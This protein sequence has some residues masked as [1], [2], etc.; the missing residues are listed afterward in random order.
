VRAP[1]GRSA[2]RDRGRSLSRE[3]PGAELLRSWE[4]IRSLPGGRRLFSLFV[5]LRAPYSGSIRAVVQKLESGL[6][7]VALRDRRSVRNHLRSVHAI[8]LTNLG[9][10]SSGLAMLTVL[11]AGTRGIVVALEV[12][13]HK[14]ARGLLIAEGKAFAPSVE[15]LAGGDV[16]SIATAVIRDVERDIVAEVRIRWRIGAVDSSGADPVPGIAASD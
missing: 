7:V 13:F 12:E 15:S 2:A 1:P 8:A 10:L 11:P 5:G 6:S 3:G 14:K 9:E 16:E 4:R